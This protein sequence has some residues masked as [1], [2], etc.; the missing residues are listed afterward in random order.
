MHLVEASY[1]VHGFL[2]FSKTENS[3]GPLTLKKNALLER[4]LCYIHL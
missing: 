2:G 4:L 1:T 3:W